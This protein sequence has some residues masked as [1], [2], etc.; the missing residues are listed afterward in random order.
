MLALV[1]TL[2][3]L[4][5]AVVVGAFVPVM[6]D[7]WV[8]LW[9]YSFV[10]PTAIAAFAVLRSGEDRFPR[11]ATGAIFGSALGFSLVQ[12]LDGYMKLP[13]WH[14]FIAI[15]PVTAVVGATGALIYW[16]ARF[17]LAGA[18]RAAV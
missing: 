16:L 17:Y 9:I 14:L 4:I 15:F 12:A 3:A 13:A 8:F 6:L 1:A 2:I 10:V 11:L 5:A 18:R 7:D